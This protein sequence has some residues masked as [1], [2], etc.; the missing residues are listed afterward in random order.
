MGNEG[1]FGSRGDGKGVRLWLG[2]AGG[3][4]RLF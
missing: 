4:A 3:K 1:G 2:G